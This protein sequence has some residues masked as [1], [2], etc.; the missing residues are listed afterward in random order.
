MDKREAIQAMVD[1]HKVKHILW[2]DG[3]YLYMQDNGDV[4]DNYLSLSNMNRQ[5]DGEWEVYDE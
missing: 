1:G 2:R 4:V 5:Q 3:L